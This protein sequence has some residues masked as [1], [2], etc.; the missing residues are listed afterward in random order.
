LALAEIQDQA[1][2]RIA[3]I[4]NTAHSEIA[5]WTL[6]GAL[7]FVAACARTLLAA[8]SGVWLLVTKGPWGFR[9]AL[10]AT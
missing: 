6:V 8:G 9:I 10:V 5:R 1:L 7:G 2:T 3:D 4:G